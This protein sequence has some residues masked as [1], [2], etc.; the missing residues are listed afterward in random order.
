VK[1]SSWVTA[2]GLGAV[3]AVVVYSSL[4][5]GSVRCEVCIRFHGRETCRAV[6][7]DTEA[8]ARMAAITNVCAGLASG[9]TDRMACEATPPARTTCGDPG[10]TIDSP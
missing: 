4:Q 5:I 3:G 2:A 9:V 10:R 8:E 7:G 1:W 6:D